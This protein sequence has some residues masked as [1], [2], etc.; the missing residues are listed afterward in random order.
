MTTWH[1]QT[2][3]ALVQVMAWCLFSAN[4]NVQAMITRLMWTIWTSLSAVRER[5][6]NLI[7]HSLTCS[8]P[9]HYLNQCWFIVNCK[10]INFREVFIKIN[11]RSRKYSL[12]YF[13]LIHVIPNSICQCYKQ[14]FIES[15][16]RIYT[17]VNWVI[18]GSDNG[19]APVH[20]HGLNFSLWLTIF[21]GHHIYIF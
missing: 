3:S 4:F 11:Y 12:K 6:L 5:P 19:L 20:H 16:W 14:Y 10:V 1:C 2:W 8:V 18:I 17:S 9:S 13:V 15:G 21:I 7:T